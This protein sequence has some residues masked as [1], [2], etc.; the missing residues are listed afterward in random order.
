MFVYTFLIVDPH[1]EYCSEFLGFPDSG[2]GATLV[3]HVPV[4]VK[5]RQLPLEQQH[6]YDD[7]GK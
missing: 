2:D 7:S 4:A 5:L 1:G 6:S 3:H